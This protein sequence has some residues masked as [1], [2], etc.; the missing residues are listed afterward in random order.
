MKF[1]KEL[2]L[3]DVFAISTGAMLSGLFLLPGL[4]YALAG[5]TV[6]ISYLA[7]AGLALTGLLS[8]AELT[9]A[10]PKAGGAYFY[11]TRS[12]G[13]A[14]GTV[15]GL[16]TWLS[17]SLKSA[18]EL[19][20]MGVF[21]AIFV[22][23]NEHLLAI[24]F[25][26]VFLGINFVGAK[27]AGRI[28]VYLVFAL[29]LL[30][31]FF[32]LRSWSSFDARNFE[33][34]DSPDFNSITAAAAL[35]FI[36]FGGLLK[37]ASIAEEVKDPGRTVPLGMILSLLVVTVLYL[38]VV[39]VT[40]AVL[41]PDLAE[42]KTPLCDTA[43]VFMGRSGSLI[44]AVAA[45]LA[46]ITAANAGIMAA[47]RYPL[48]L[49]RDGMLPAILACINRPWHTPHYSI[50]LTGSIIISAL[51]LNVTVLVKA[52]STVLILTYIF[53]CLAVVILR[54][55]R[56]QNYR[57]HFRSPLY[58]WVQLIG[59][60]GFVILL[61][62]LGATGLITTCVLTMAGFMVYWLYGRKQFSREY[63]LLHL[64]ERI[65][66][67]RLTG[68]SLE[69]ELKDIIHER[70]D[71]LKDR[72][73]QLVESSPV[74]DLEQS[75]S[76]EQFFRQTAD[77]LAGNLHVTA[78]HILEMLL[79]RERESSTV[80]NPFLAIPHIVI[81]GQKTFAL[82]LG[83]C[84]DGIVFSETAP[85]VHTVFV[86]IGTRDE[87]PFHL[88]T[89]AAIAQIVQD[90]D[91]ETRWMDARNDQGLRDVILLGKRKRQRQ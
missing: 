78:D 91:F 26:V 7:A 85:R 40:V 48:A 79:H 52:A 1:K 46:I 9:S 49:A 58:P 50:L 37:V 22:S 67:R 21:A 59:F 29:L 74:L 88:T 71:I 82:L 84:R 76:A 81:E 12:M 36:S 30:L 83:R 53:S 19:L 73:D 87:R 31:V 8:Q 77:A 61:F 32:V 69:K 70:D 80:L 57:P 33:S 3:L 44:M 24:V 16:I 35:I 11:V 27:I 15:Y 66:D 75:V 38:S 4:A 28:Q 65:T 6:L 10:M 54:E 68:H 62:E 90:E 41:G 17:M 23:L 86:L 55:S 45:I 25:C 14:V 47:S 18:Y 51:F 89:L 60:I 63:A 20:F 5:S 2:N 72:F 42:S 64:I 13:S 39:F 34:F 43:A 56:V